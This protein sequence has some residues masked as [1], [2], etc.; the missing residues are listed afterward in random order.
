MK[1]V[2]TTWNETLYIDG[3]PGKYA[4]IARRHNNQWYVAGVNGQKELVKIKIQLPMFAGK[5]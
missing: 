4:V 2:P 3:Y 5:K 1:T